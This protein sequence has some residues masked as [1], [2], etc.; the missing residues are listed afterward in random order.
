M[1]TEIVFTVRD[2]SG[3]ESETG[4]KVG[5]VPTVT[6]LN[7]FS[8]AWA[9]ALNNIIAGKIMGAIAR[10]TVNLATLTGNILSNNADVEHTGKF[11]FLTAQGNRVVCNIPALSEI[12]IGATTADELN[13]AQADVA[14]FI[15]AIEDGINVTGALI[16]PCDEGED[17]IVSTSF[18]REA[19]RNSGAKR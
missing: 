7:A 2:A 3:D 14:A 19:F 8:S 9:T 1:V 5:G 16:E 17:D 11:L 10:Q 12:A 4:V 15:A 6:Q 13:Q 18:A